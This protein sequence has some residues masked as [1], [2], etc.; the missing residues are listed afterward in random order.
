MNILWAWLYSWPH[1]SLTKYYFLVYGS[2]LFIYLGCIGSLLL[3]ASFS[4]R[5]LLLSQSIGSGV[6]VHMLNCPAACGIF[7][8]QGWTH[9]PC[10]ARQ[11]LNCWTTGEVQGYGSIESKWKMSMKTI[12]PCSISQ[13]PLNSKLMEK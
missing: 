3:C 12:L 2:I 8:D 5:R 11:I 4:L 6:V 1:F 13:T 10:I 7:P 9:V